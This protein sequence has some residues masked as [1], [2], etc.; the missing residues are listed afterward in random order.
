MIQ[1]GIL[2]IEQLSVGY[3]RSDR[4]TVRDVSL[5][6][7]PGEVTGLIGPNG[8]GKTTLIRGL[9][10]RAR[11]VSGSV[12]FDGSDVLAMDARAR[13]RILSIVPQSPQMPDGYSVFDVVAM[14]RTAY[15]GPFGRL[16]AADR[17]RIESAIRLTGIET[18]R[19]RN[20]VFLSG[21]ER[22]RVLI[23]RAVAQD[24]PVI[25][26]DEPTAHLDLRYQIRLLD[27]VLSYSRERGVAALLILHD[28]NL[29]AR[30]TDRIMIL[31]RGEVAAIGE[32][33]AVLAAERLSEIYRIPMERIE[34]GDGKTALFAPL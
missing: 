20:C 25:V 29:A 17:E 30:Y 4:A 16:T 26:L 34:R 33:S 7:R 2:R 28:L 32:T 15:R 1:P 3:G 14:G 8:S 27:L 19:E 22:Q 18:L 10:G 11:V 13:A 12:L 21:G 31:A 5:E 9:S 24:T 6:L 23:A